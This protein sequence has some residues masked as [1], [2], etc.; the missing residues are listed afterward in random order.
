MRAR[1]FGTQGFGTQGFGTQG[2]GTQGFGTRPIRLLIGSE[3]LMGE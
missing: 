2:F 1:G 3:D